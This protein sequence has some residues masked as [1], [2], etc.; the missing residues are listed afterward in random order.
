MADK[1]RE[2]ERA[3]EVRTSCPVEITCPLCGFVAPMTAIRCPRCNALLLTACS[4]SCASCG[5]RACLL[6]DD[7]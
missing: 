7:E 2:P 3:E 1:K 6:P 5:S 4:G